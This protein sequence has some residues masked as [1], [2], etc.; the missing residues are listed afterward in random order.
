MHC[1]LLIYFA[2]PMWILPNP[3]M[4]RLGC[5]PEGTNVFNSR[6]VTRC[7]HGN[8]WTEIG[9]DGVQSKEKWS[10]PLPLVSVSCYS[11]YQ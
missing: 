11:N 1:I 8:S 6:A 3:Q 2:L 9:F 7:V 10:A 4:A 5:E